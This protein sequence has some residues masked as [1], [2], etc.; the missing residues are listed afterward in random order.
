MIPQLA[1]IPIGSRVNQLL[2][3]VFGALIVVIEGLQQLYQSLRNWLLYRSTCESLK[4]EKYLFLA[5]AA[6]LRSGLGPTRAVGRTNRSSLKSMRSCRVRNKRRKRT[7]R[8]TW[9]RNHRAY[10]LKSAD[11]G[12]FTPL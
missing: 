10:S 4:H 7:S 5:S 8:P 6:S 3:A 9:P 12:S 11:Q 1:A 2:A